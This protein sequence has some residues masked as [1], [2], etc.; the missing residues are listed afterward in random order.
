MKLKNSFCSVNNLVR[1]ELK[2]DK[3]T[4]F[5]AER[6]VCASASPEMSSRLS[7]HQT[8]AHRGLRGRRGRQGGRGGRG[9]RGGRGGDAALSAPCDLPL[10]SVNSGQKVQISPQRLSDTFNT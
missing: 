10:S 9:R 7:L 3:F 2:Q 8:S 4:W 5:E 6:Q 1:L